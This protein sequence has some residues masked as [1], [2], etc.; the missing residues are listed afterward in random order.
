[1]Y[2]MNQYPGRKESPLPAGAEE[3]YRELQAGSRNVPG[4]YIAL[5]EW[6]GLVV[7]SGHWEIIYC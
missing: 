2:I 4:M 6:A 3:A 5:W 1:M 7:V